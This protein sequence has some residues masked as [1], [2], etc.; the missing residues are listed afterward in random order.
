MSVFDVYLK[1][2]SVDETVK[3]FIENYDENHFLELYD[4]ATHL[5]RYA[6]NIALL[7]VEDEKITIDYSLK[8]LEIKMDV[9]NIHISAYEYKS[10]D[11]KF[12]D[13]LNCVMIVPLYTA[14]K[15]I[16]TMASKVSS[17]WNVLFLKTVDMLSVYSELIHFCVPVMRLCFPNGDSKLLI[18]NKQENIFDWNFRYNII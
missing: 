16:K 9:H 12:H 6:N 18:R 17:D 4:I 14:K 2:K 13:T 11:V 3:Y 8:Y 10:G 1:T 7:I 15:H 5:D